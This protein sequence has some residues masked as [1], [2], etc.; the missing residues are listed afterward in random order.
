MRWG[1]SFRLRHLTTGHY[2]ALTED[3][4]L[5]IQDRERSDTASTAFCFR[6]SKVRGCFGLA[7]A[8][9]CSE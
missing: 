2:L 3:Q 1:Q 7:R 9:L 6:V 5:V 4:G 8:L